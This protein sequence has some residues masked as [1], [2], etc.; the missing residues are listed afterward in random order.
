MKPSFNYSGYSRLRRYLGDYLGDMYLR[1]VSP[2]L[3]CVRENE[4][5]MRNPSSFLLNAMPRS[6]RIV[7]PDVPHHLI[8]RGNRRQNV[9][10]SGDDKAH[11]LRL[12]LKWSHIAG[13]IIWAYCLMDNHVHFVAVPKRAAS[14]AEAFGQTHKAYT[15]TIN[16]CHGWDGYLWQGRFISYPMDDPYLYRAVRY[17]ELNPVRAQ[18]VDRAEEYPWSSAR[19]HV[20]GE[21]NIILG[22][23][24]LGMNGREWAAYLAEGLVESETELFR[25]HA[26]T[27]RPLGDE[28][29]LRKIGEI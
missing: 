3:L 9:F 17:V 26:N 19:A 5:P 27:G 2:F 24:P 14:L 13:I 7:I 10:F 22:R 1:Y 18:V 23:A 15:K 12:L 20:L 25:D 4:K 6:A 16:K 29:F 28:S 11:Y 8:Q 21:E